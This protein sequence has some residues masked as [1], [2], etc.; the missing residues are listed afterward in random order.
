MANM[1]LTNE[2]MLKY[3]RRIGEELERSGLKGEII[4]TGGASMCLVHG[5]RKT[6]LDID[7]L[8]EPDTAI[9]LIAYKI[10]EDE[11]LPI[12]WLNDAVQIFVK[13]DAPVDSFM[14]FKGLNVSTVSAEYLLAMKIYANRLDE[15]DI[16]DIKFLSNK[17]DITE[18]EQA[19]DI[20]LKYFPPE[21]ASPESYV[22][23][24]EVFDVL[25]NKLD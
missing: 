5:A 19:L 25:K 24:D 13:P 23:L 11:G 4:L 2:L 21:R 17:L 8:F 10:A 22:K 16:A 15:K 7:A 12:T 1:L 20:L 6:T 18:K 14:K 9:R 3:L